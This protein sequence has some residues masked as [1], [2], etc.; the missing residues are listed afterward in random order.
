MQLAIQNATKILT[1]EIDIKLEV[2]HKDAHKR[3]DRMEDGAEK[4][5]DTMTLKLDK[6]T[7]NT[8]DILVKQTAQNVTTEFLALK[9]DDHETGLSNTKKAIFAVVVVIVGAIVTWMLP[10]L[11]T[12]TP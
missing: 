8:G 9:I 10:M 1:A 12:P 11:N 2:V 3:M 5:F 4:V 7:E 6:I